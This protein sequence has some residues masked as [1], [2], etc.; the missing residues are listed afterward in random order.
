MGAA[1]QV[2]S[3]AQL[4]GI[5]QSSPKVVVDI[6]TDWCGPCKAIAPQFANLP[7]QFPGVTF[8]KVNF[9]H[10]RDMAQMV[11]VKGVPT[12]A[13]FKN[14]QLV[15][16]FSGANMARIVQSTTALAR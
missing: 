9:D 12:F 13:F 1:V 7:G 15:D 5:I 11:E 16:F 10:N 8:C 14:G 2:V 3:T 4:R 6:Y